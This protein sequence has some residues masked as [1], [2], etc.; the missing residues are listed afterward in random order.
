VSI[1]KAQKEQI[2]AEHGRHEKDTGSPEAQI[3]LMTARITELTEHFKVHKKDH[4]SLRG[5]LKIVGRRRRLL[6]YLR[7]HDIE[8][9]RKLI[10]E[11]GI[12]G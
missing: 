9:Y 1:E 6:S 10:K 12:R 2:L 5:L 11:L 4:H 7:R 3:A 8:R